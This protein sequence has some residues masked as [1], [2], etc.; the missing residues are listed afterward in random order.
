MLENYYNLADAILEEATP[1]AILLL[2]GAFMY[3]ALGRSKILHSEKK[4]RLII[5]A[6]LSLYSYHL[7]EV[8]AWNH[9]ITIAA[10]GAAAGISSVLIYNLFLHRGK[11][12]EESTEV[13]ERV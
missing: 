9:I 8:N 7:V 10:V 3:A 5:S 4:P 6:V 2:V 13:E 11:T 12:K 1:I